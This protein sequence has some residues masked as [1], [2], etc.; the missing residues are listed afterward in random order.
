MM[1]GARG[2][3]RRMGHHQHLSF[4]GQPRQP[5]ADGGCG[6]AADAAIDLIENQCCDR[7]R[8]SQYDFQRQHETRELT[9]RCDLVERPGR[10]AGDGRNLESDALAAM[11]VPLAL[12]Q[13]CQCG[14]ETRL[15]QLQRRQF[16]HDRGVELF[17]GGGACFGD[18]IGGGEIGLPCLGL[19]PRQ[20][21]DCRAAVVERAELGSEIRLQLREILDRDI[22]LAS[23][24]AQREEPFFDLFE[25]RWALEGAGRG[26]ELGDRLAGLDNSALQCRGGSFET[27]AGFA[28]GA[29]DGARRA[30]ER[31]LGAAIAGELR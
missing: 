29:L 31:M 12:G 22:V 1:R 18:G 30:G 2:N 9:A 6:C 11:L 21:R 26:F 24:R 15:L 14:V 17:R 10:R 16:L 23:K 7:R 19:A 27:P 28:F 8:L 4:L 5:L 13:R 20:R 3:L 25:A